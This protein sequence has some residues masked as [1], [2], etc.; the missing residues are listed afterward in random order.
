MDAKDRAERFEE[1]RRVYGEWHAHL[2]AHSECH[3]RPTS[4]GLWAASTPHDVF[5]LLTALSAEGCRHFADLGS[6][7]GLVTCIAS[8]FCPATGIECDA[9]LV[10]KANELRDRL[11]LSAEFVCGDFFAQDLS[12]FDLLYVYPDKPMWDLEKALAPRLRGRLVAY[13]CHFPLKLLPIL[14][15]V[16]LGTCRATVYGPLPEVDA[17][18]PVP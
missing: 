13:S 15:T 18:R 5:A 6:G 1:I 3:A 4:R 10:E 7:D 12:R 17:G 2:A 14:D 8:L 9:G 11:G 16:S